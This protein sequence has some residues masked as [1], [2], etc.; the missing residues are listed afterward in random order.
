MR[1]KLGLTAPVVVA[2]FLVGI[3][4]CGQDS[5]VTAPAGLNTPDIHATVTAL[6]L[7]QAQ[8]LTPTP[9]PEGVR[10]ELLA[11]AA[12][13]ESTAVDWDQFH[14]E[15][16]QWRNGVVVCA[17]A[18]V[19][20]ALEGFAGRALGVTQT[21]RSLDRLPY[22]EDLA[23]R[24]TAAAEHEEF[25][26]E[27]LSSNWQPETGLSSGPLSQAPG[28]FQQLASVR[29]SVD[30]ERGEVARSLLARQTSVDGA[31]LASVESF[32]SSM[33]ML[34][35]DWDQ[36]HR[37]YDAFR[38]E[39]VQLGDDAAATKLGDLVIQFASIVDDVQNLPDTL[40]TREIA[41]RLADAADGEQLLIRRLLGS[42]GGDGALVVIETVPVLPD[43]LAITGNSNGE[44]GT[45]VLALDGATVF[46]VF[47]TQIALVN[48]LRRGLRDDLTSARASLTEPGQDD[49]AV[50][51][52][53]TKELEQ[54]WDD[55]HV[56]YDEW[57]RT[58]GGCDQGRALEQ[59]G[60]LA[61][62][63][64]QIVRDV[65]DLSSLPLVREMGEIL[66]QSVEREQAALLS[67]RESWRSLD[68]SAFGRYT[69]D[70]AFADTLRRQVAL[71]LQDLLARQ[72]IP[73]EN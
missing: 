42:I 29:S 70:R 56:S 40:L 52:G 24:L 5:T 73:G 60:Q 15:M 47:D 11:F 43:E 54:E 69:A 50:F 35:S 45:S 59:L 9:V 39:Q 37:D 18:S 27:V 64:S 72:G 46:D 34:D 33:E 57:R 28:L 66:I 12:G 22:L 62:D 3:V 63:F 51:I 49:L 6:A 61:N 26:F 38:V 41:D 67:L 23:D 20:S 58:N 13:H 7:S 25:A 10:Q 68:T 4:A 55:L 8:A 17:P 1:F 32:A 71:D 21:A 30:L 14:Q 16:D 2:V 53:Q 48:R 65:K 31:I 44:T 36:F 19:E